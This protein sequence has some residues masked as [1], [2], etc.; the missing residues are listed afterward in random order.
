M[1]KKATQQHFNIESLKNP[2]IAQRYQGNAQK[3]LTSIIQNSADINITLGAFNKSILS[4]VWNILEQ[5]RSRRK[6]WI[7]DEVL[8]LSDAKK[9]LKSQKHESQE[10]QFQY[11]SLTWQIHDKVKASKEEWIIG[12]CKEAEAAAIK[13]DSKTLYNKIKE[14]SAGPSKKPQVR[15]IRDNQKN[16]LASNQA[17][18]D[19]WKEYCESLYN[20]KLQSDP[21]VLQELQQNGNNEEESPFMYGEVQWALHKLKNGKI[22]WLRWYSGRIAEV[23]WNGSLSDLVWH[24]L[25]NLA[26]RI[27]ARTMDSIHY[28][29]LI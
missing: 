10:F 21:S 25:K 12:K 2:E 1:Q 9:G 28:N 27:L 29:L 26:L 11:N 4:A 22:T 15:A 23:W 13:N 3:E 16:L 8:R 6:P 24:L 5:R 19:H 18:E 14:I 20:Y 17:I 7:S